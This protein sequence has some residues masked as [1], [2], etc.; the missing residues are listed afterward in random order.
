MCQHPEL[1]AINPDAVHMI[2]GDRRA[3]ATIAFFIPQRPATSIAQA[4]I[5]RCSSQHPGG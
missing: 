4:L 5:Q 2:T 1:S 3:K